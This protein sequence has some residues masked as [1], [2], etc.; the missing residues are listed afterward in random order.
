MG[1]LIVALILAA[2]IAILWVI[3]TLRERKHQGGGY[4]GEYDSAGRMSL[5]T[6]AQV[7][8][9]TAQRHPPF[10]GSEAFTDSDVVE[11]D[12]AGKD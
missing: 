2:P 3:L 4:N 5:L 7:S 9:M 1:T 10:E 12:A 6:Y 8:A 11:V